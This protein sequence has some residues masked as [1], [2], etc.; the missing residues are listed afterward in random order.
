MCTTGRPEYALEAWRF[1]DPHGKLIPVNDREKRFICVKHDKETVPKHM[2]AVLGLKRPWAK[3]EA[4]ARS[5]M[6]LALIVDDRTDV[7]IMLPS[8]LILWAPMSE[9][10]LMPSKQSF[11]CT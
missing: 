5:P 2:E 11:I 7:R 8:L 4:E 6:P 10:S 3:H 1:L 9:D